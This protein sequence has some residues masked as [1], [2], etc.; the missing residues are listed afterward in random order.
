MVSTTFRPHTFSAMYVDIIDIVQD[1]VVFL[2]TKAC[3]CPYFF[4]K[5]VGFIQLPWPSLSSSKQIQTVAQ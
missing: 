1:P 4:I 2:G 3:L 5:E